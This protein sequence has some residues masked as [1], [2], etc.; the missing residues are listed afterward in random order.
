M[1][2]PQTFHANVVHLSVYVEV[3]GCDP[4]AKYRQLLPTVSVSLLMPRA[5]AV[6]Y[7]SPSV[8][9]SELWDSLQSLALSK[10]WYH[11]SANPADLG[12]G[13]QLDGFLDMVLE[14]YH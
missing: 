13:Q 1:H 6:T 14:A 11:L 5:R 3:L 9:G 2:V 7:A 4:Q 8:Q 10:A 12:A